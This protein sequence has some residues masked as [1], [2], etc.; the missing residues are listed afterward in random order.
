MSKEVSFG[1]I[2][3]AKID[4][5][6]SRIFGTPVN[7]TGDPKGKR[8]EWYDRPGKIIGVQHPD[9]FVS[10]GSKSTVILEFDVDG[11]MVSRRRFDQVSEGDNV[12][13][14]PEL[15]DYRKELPVAS[16]GMQN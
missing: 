7:S 8:I 13:S 6:I 3:L 16:G 12:L 2:I 10:I 4:T 14:D 1:Q 11:K 5:T 15:E 9:G